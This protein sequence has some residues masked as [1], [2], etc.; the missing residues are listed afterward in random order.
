MKRA[1]LVS[2]ALIFSSLISLPS[3]AAK[4]NDPTPP[5]PKVVFETSV[6]N[7]TIELYPKEAPVTVEN[8]LRYVDEGF[9]T[10]TI[11]HRVVPNFVVQGGGFTWDFQR[12]ETHDAIINEADNKLKNEMAT[13]SMARSSDPASATSQFFINIKDNEALDFKK[14]ESAGYAVFGKVI[15]GFETVKKIEREP[16]GL[17]RDRPEAPNYPVIVEKAYRLDP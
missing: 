3:F 8:F 10:G 7:M 9:Y 16:R 4:K 6:G 11:F 17:Y 12:K 2:V 14:G 15:E 1:L 5:F 13:L